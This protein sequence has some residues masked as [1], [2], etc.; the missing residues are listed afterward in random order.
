MNRQMSQMVGS[1]G[2]GSKSMAPTR[3][4]TADRPL[5]GRCKRHFGVTAPSVHQM[6]LALERA[7]SPPSDHGRTD[8]SIQR[9]VNGPPARALHLQLHANLTSW[10]NA[11]EVFFA[12]L[13]SGE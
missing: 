1:H 12:N 3:A 6:I 11:I 10:L 13:P 2:P 4:S 9:C 5:N 8:T 7:G